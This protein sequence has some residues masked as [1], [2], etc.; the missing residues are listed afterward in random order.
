MIS[1]MISVVLP[2]IHTRTDANT[3]ASGV[4]GRALGEP[5]RER[6]PRQG[7]PVLAARQPVQPW[8]SKVCTVHWAVC[9]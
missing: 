5:V 8:V 2:K 6:Q 4:A 1:F 3:S 7:H 9:G